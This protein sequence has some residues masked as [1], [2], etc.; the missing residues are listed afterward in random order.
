MS[1]NKRGENASKT[2]LLVGFAA[3]ILLFIGYSFNVVFSCYEIYGRDREPFALIA[4]FLA[5]SFIILS[6]L[7]E[8]GVD[9]FS[10]RLIGHGRY[11]SEDVW[12]KIISFLFI[13]GGTFDIVAFVFWMEREF[14]VEKKFLFASAYS[15]LA[16]AG[17]V[18]FF[19]VKENDKSLTGR[20]DLFG[21]ILVLVAAILNV[22]VRHLVK[23]DNADLEDMVDRMDF[24]GAPIWLVSSGFYVITDLFLLK[25]NLGG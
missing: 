8:L 10:S 21:N 17:I 19:Q 2:H 4:Y 13:A 11:T 9:V 22:I 16:M 15:V 3:N 23:A 14:Q 6:G 18:M 25:A 5:F 12:N 24:T 7:F 20:I 1:N